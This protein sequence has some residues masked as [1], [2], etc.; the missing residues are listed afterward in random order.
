MATPPTQQSDT[1][2][3]KRGSV[4]SNCKYRARPFSHRSLAS[5]GAVFLPW[6][7]TFH[8]DFLSQPR[9]YIPGRSRNHV[10]VRSDSPFYSHK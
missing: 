9:T 10:R 2:S 5:Q 1:L 7:Q 3:G 4:A 6:K 8:L